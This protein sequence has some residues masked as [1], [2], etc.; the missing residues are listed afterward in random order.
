MGILLGFNGIFLALVI[1]SI[2]SS[3]EEKRFIPAFWDAIGKGFIIFGGPFVIEIVVMA[4]YSCYANSLVAGLYSR[5]S[6][7]RSKMQDVTEMEA[8]A[9]TTVVQD[10]EAGVES[11]A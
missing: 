6:N 2:L 10:E 8:M 9:K 7:M 5:Y 3:G 4:L 11:K 1:L